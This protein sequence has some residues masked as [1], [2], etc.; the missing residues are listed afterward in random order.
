[1]KIIVKPKVKMKKI[2]LV[3]LT[4]F[5]VI[6]S[7]SPICA[8]E[9]TPIGLVENNVVQNDPNFELDFDSE[10]TFYTFIYD[11]NC[12]WEVN[13]VIGQSNC[14]D[15]YLYTKNF[16]TGVI[17]QLVNV[18][19]SRFYEANNKVYFPYDNAIYSVDYL[20]SQI[21]EIYKTNN[22]VI[23]ENCIKVIGNDIYFVLDNKLVKYNMMSRDIT[24]LFSAVGLS[25]LYIKSNSEFIYLVDKEIHYV[26]LNNNLSVNA[27]GTTSFNSNNEGYTNVILNDI[28]IMDRILLEA[29]ETSEGNVSVN[30][31][32]DSYQK[33]Y[34]LT[35]ILAQYPNNSYFTYD[36]GACYH[37]GTGCSY[38]GG[39]NCRYYDYAIQCMGFA[40]YASD[41]YAH[42]SSWN[43]PSTEQYEPNCHFNS[44][45]QIKT[46]FDRMTTGAY[47]LLSHN[48]DENGFHA[49]FYVKSDSNG[50][51][52]YECNIN[53]HC[54]VATYYTT[55][56]GYKTRF[57]TCYGIYTVS[58]NYSSSA[59][60]YNGNFHKYS[61]TTCGG[62]ILEYHYGLTLGNGTCMK[63]GYT[64]NIKYNYPMTMG[65]Y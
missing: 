28:C 46:Y 24:N 48:D 44:V 25:D 18:G 5:L 57:N 26:N 53:G 35:Q 42:K 32:T 56:E 14:I 21:S 2:L 4:S 38:S 50:V 30:S 20:G 23:S 12:D 29:V 11:S 39:C 6:S 33:D 52:T 15:G 31:S 58:H 17:R 16:D 10:L 49:M 40:K 45:N 62:Y 27:I 47:V 34:N 8:Q 51:T 13:Y 1:M 36:G 7:I 60:N 37:H 43:P 9:R 55:Y 3:F 59:T 64:G 63:C 61:C 65:D 19:I 54:D 41:R 22:K